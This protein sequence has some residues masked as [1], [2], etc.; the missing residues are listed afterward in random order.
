MFAADSSSHAFRNGFFNGRQ[1]HFLEL[2]KQIGIGHMGS[3]E[4]VEKVSRD[5]APVI[6]V[7]QYLDIEILRK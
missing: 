5:I 7:L 4:G 1:S 3:N 2:G 6:V